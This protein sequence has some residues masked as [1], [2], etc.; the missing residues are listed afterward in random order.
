MSSDQFREHLYKEFLTFFDNAEQHRRWNPLQ[1]VPWDRIN[2]ETPEA[3]ALCAE[4]FLGVEGFLPD[5][6]GGGLQVFRN[7]SVGQRWFVANWGY[8]ELKHS[9]ALQLYLVRSGKRTEEQMADYQAKLMTE[10]W[11]PPFDTARR[12]TIYGALQEMAT[13]V[14]YVRQEKAAKEAGDEALAA[15]YRLNARDE[16]AHARFYEMTVRA[17]LEEDREGT[18]L[19]IAHVAANFQMPGVGIVPDYDARIAVMRDAGRIDR[20]VFLQKVYLPTLRRLGVERAEI[21]A[22]ISAQRKAARA[23]RDSARVA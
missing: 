8:E 9:M 18:V 2:R 1:D 12:I 16:C 3:M 11:V 20:D 21:T 19:D 5:Y 4:T 10:E 6:I 15:I 7:E 22:A 23:A 17:Y 14:I 13:F